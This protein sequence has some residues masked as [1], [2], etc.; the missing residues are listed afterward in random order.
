[1]YAIFVN[2]KI[3]EKKKKE[4]LKPNKTTHGILG[5]K[6]CLLQQNLQG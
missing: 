1:M 6:P 2:L 5:W 4:S 3:I